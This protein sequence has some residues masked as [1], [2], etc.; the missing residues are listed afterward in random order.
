MKQKTL[1][2]L[3]K[4]A[5]HYISGEEISKELGVSRT[6]IW[7]YISLLKSDGYM[8]DAASKKG[9]KL[10]NAKDLMESAFYDLPEGQLIGSKYHYLKEIDSTN[11]YSKKIAKESKEGTVVI[12]NLQTNGKGRLGKSWESL[13]GKGLWMSVI[14]KPRISI[15]GIFMLS[16]LA[17][18][19]VCKALIEEGY[20]SGI[21]WPN[22]VVINGKKVCG[23]LC[24]LDGEPERLNYVIVGIGLNLTHDM[25]DF[26][27]EIRV[28]ATSLLQEDDR[29]VQSKVILEK[30]L[31]NLDFFYKQLCMGNS[32][33]II[34]YA[35][36]H[37]E[38]IGKEIKV[39][40]N[41]DTLIGKAIDINDVGGLLI[42]TK[43]GQAMEIISGEVSVRGINGYI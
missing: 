4:N 25:N 31:I 18:A 22:D 1:Q 5:N 34:K 43:D 17:G 11:S 35:R 28:R 39:I 8:I 21:K 16:H 29:T 6:A 23:I 14:L 38:T 10:A 15:S 12:S 9:Y 3:F 41:D 2:I 7:K 33:E 36:E 27:E 40:Y 37:S 20:N 30:I 32:M 26:P 13:G 42:E 24:E 19:A